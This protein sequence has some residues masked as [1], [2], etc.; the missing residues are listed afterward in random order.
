MPDNNENTEDRR[1]INNVEDAV[2]AATD[3]A[4]SSTLDARSTPPQPRASLQRVR[5]STE[6]DRPVLDIDTQA[7]TLSADTHPEQSDVI[8]IPTHSISGA[9]ASPRRRNRGY[10][11]RRQLFFRNAENQLQD[12][13][14]LGQIAS[15]VSVA[16]TTSSDSAP[17]MSRL[18]KR[19]SP[20]P[21]NP[22]IPMLPISHPK[23]GISPGTPSLW[24]QKHYHP[25][26]DRIFSFCV[27]LKKTILRQHELPPTKEGRKIPLDLTR[28]ENL[29]DERTGRHYVNNTVRGGPAK[30]SPT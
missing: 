2:S 20:D 21:K 26:R 13:P 16:H 4:R 23:R 7:T 25:H 5:F 12:P 28:T 1:P 14:V 15:E 24:A 8:P 9:P 30:L 18:E 6:T 3:A 11:L 19:T 27:N 22:D 10:S 17:D 29:I